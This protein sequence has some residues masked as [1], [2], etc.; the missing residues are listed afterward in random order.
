MSLKRKYQLVLLSL[1][2]TVPLLL[3]LINIL[4]NGIYR[5]VYRNGEIPFYE[6]FAYPAMHVLFAL[7]LL[8]LALLFAK[9]I[10]SLLEKITALNK[11]VHELAA[12][13]RIP[14]RLPVEN[15]DELGDL[16]RSVN[17]LIDRTTYRELELQQ[18]EAMKR[19]LLTK[20]RHDIN[21]PL[22][23]MR[24]QLYSLEGDVDQA[25]LESMYQQIQYISDLTNEMEGPAAKMAEES[26]IVSE[27]VRINDLLE[28][29]VRK[30]S[31][32]YS[33]HGMEVLFTPSANELVWTSNALWLQRLFDNVFQNSLN[34]S[35]A[36][37]FEVTIEN[38]TVMLRD[39]GVGFERNG[40][41]RGLGLEIID[42]IAMKLGLTY[43]LK[44]DEDG[45]VYCFKKGK[46]K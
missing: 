44:T 36:K 10:N 13:K 31:Y 12:D 33:L 42:D 20:L 11:T 43:T 37:R 1:I 38:R 26:Y 24:L 28:T 35:R 18:Q 25:V 27:E 23:A 34:H 41:M 6:S 3:V 14:H 21:T 4:M 40:A 9:S 5:L 19:E 46:R 39:N 7:A 30:W 32:L 22:T 45:T 15:K 2:I 8:G 16:T 17:L 29:M